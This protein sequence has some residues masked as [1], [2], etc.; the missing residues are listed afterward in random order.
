MGKP[1]YVVRI[2][3]GSNTVTLGPREEVMHR[4]LSASGVNWLIDEPKSAFRATVRIRYNGR[5]AAAK[6]VPR[7]DCAVVEFDEPNLAITP[8]QLA[9]FYLEQENGKRVAG[10]AWI[11][12]VGD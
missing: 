4:R 11:E 2:E 8:G 7:G 3:A 1:Y 10:G 9:V 12:E 5:G 6:V